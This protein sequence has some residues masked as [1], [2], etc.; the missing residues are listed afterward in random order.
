MSK[1][2]YQIDG[3]LFS[4]LEEFYEH[5]SK[6]VLQDNDWGRN[7]DAFND[8]LWGG[9]GTP[10]E[11]FVLLWKYSNISREKL[12]YSETIRQLRHRLQTCHSTNREL[13]AI[14]LEKAMRHEGSTVFDWIVEIILYHKD[15]E[16]L[17]E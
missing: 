14:D 5:F 13:V 12:N 6:V 4:T 1:K 11:G 10:D 15:I 8:V 16:L 9:F 7:L 3:Q 2:I 17:L